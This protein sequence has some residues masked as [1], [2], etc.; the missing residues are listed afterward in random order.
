MSQ[1]A[2]QNYLQIQNPY[3]V[4]NVYRYPSWLKHYTRR[5]PPQVLAMWESVRTQ[6]ADTHSVL[7]ATEDVEHLLIRGDTKSVFWCCSLSGPI[8]YH[9]EQNAFRLA[10]VLP[11][12]AV[13]LKRRFFSNNGAPSNAS[14]R[15]H[16]DLM[17]LQCS[18]WVVEHD[19]T[20]TGLTLTTCPLSQAY[21]PTISADA[22]R[23]PDNYFDV[24]YHSHVLEH[25]GG[26][27]CDC[28]RNVSVSRH[29]GVVRVVV[30]NLETIAQLY[31]KHLDNALRAEP[32]A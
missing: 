22:C 30:P 23:F 14:E 18:T 27:G 24:V 20:R 29:G 2:D 17:V 10:C 11:L 1:W 32:H 16:E 5:H 8:V 25:F 3:R 13:L 15:S 7:R 6:K 4:H 21:W 26:W 19:F 28:C 31:I 9:A 12:S